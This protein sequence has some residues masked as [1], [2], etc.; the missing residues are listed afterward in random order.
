MTAEEYLSQLFSISHHIKSEMQELQMDREMM[1][2]LGSPGFEQ[3]YSPNHPQES[4][5]ERAYARLDEK[6]RKIEQEIAGMLALEEEIKG[7]IEAVE[8]DHGRNVL[9]YRF[10]NKYP[11]ER[12][13]REMSAD[14][15]T[16]KRWYETGLRQVVV[17]EKNSEI[18]KSR[19]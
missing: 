4:P 3:S 13:A 12:I 11:W 6:Q 5:F 7:V 15:H 17:P 1:H 19:T 14:R 10:C 18:S 8:D 2:S 16:I 9:R